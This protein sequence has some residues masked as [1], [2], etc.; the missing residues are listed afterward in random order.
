LRADGARRG[1]SLLARTGTSVRPAW[2]NELL[3]FLLLLGGAAILGLVFDRALLFMLLATLAYACRLLYWLYRLERWLTRERTP[4][5][6]EAPGLWGEVFDELYRFQRRNRRR[7]LRIARLIRAFRNSTAAMPD[8]VVALNQD[9]QI[10]WFNDAAARLLGLSRQQDAGQHIGNLVRHPAF[11]NYIEEA[12]FRGV[13][14]I[15]SP[16]DDNL[17]LTLNIVAY[18]EGDHLLLVRDVTRMHRLEQMR[19]EFVANASH[20]LRSPLTVVS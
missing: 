16:V 20:E 9:W 7:K 15:E 2:T 4:H 6:P 19:R 10:V 5:P 12:G 11:V 3:R 14:E 18:G 1:L 17:R 8:G 13:V